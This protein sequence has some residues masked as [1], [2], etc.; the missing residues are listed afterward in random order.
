MKCP[1]CDTINPDDSKFCKECAAPLTKVKGVSFTVTLKA[2]KAGFS[3]GT[4]IAGKYKI[5]EEIGRGGMAVVYKA[6]DTRLKRIVALKFLSAE[7]TQNKEAKQRFIQEAQAAAALDHPNICTVHEVDEADEQT[8]IAMSYI[9]GKSLKDKLRDGPLDVEEAREIAL[10]VAEGLKEAH[11][12]GIVHRDIKPANIM[13]TD[14]SI[15]KIT[16]FGLAKLSG[17]ADL[18]KAS[19]IMGTVAYMSPEQAKGEEV[20]HRSDI[21]SLGAMVYEML[22]GERPFKKDQEH[23]LIYSILSE[24][25]ITI[26]KIRKDIP[27][28]IEVVIEKSL[29]KEASNRYQKI[30][31]LITDLEQSVPLIFPKAEKSIVVLPFEDMSPNKDQEYFSDGLTEEIISD[32]SSIQS[33]RVIS[34]TS[35]MMLKGTKKSM[36]TIGR[37]LDVQYVLEGSVR[38]A[39][40]KLRITAQLIDAS[41]DAHL[42][43]E[44]YNGTLD[45]VFDIQENVSR[46][47]V[48]ALKLKLSADEDKKISE[49]PITDIRA[50]ECYLK[51]LHEAW[52][53]TPEGLEKA[54]Q[55]LRNGLKIIGENVLFYEGLATVNL[56]YVAGGIKL[57]QNLLDEAKAYVRKIFT[58]DPENAGGH[59][60]LG[61]TAYKVGD[62][63]TAL[64]QCKKTYLL[65]PNHTMNLAGLI[66]MYS[67]SGRLSIAT[68]FAKRL[69]EIDPLNPY[70]DSMHGWKLVMEG[71]FE[72]AILAHKRTVEQ[73]PQSIFYRFCYGQS[74]AYNNQVEEACSVFEEIRQSVDINSSFYGI[75]SFYKYSLLGRKKKR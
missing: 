70:G 2:P 27:S 13:L 11:E 71:R 29:E 43:A 14:R 47:I 6:E 56:W 57:E 32:L 65:D 12:K 28:H 61:M 45:D 1:K 41:S 53:F 48:A 51:A 34:R 39:G 69:L 15:A 26:S 58:M 68:Q 72:D 55:Y 44:K 33:L 67:E 54:S 21:W 64:K 3:K 30:Q 36:K 17:G 7:L 49:R 75:V 5:I 16:D 52:T 42:W 31:E 4:V 20:D 19:T 63:K 24:D 40:N 46:S 59:Y 66:I 8:F 25:P 50:Y 73:E 22:S 35:A 62:Y 9:E 10:Q 38:T 60:I 37:E 23:A 74:L 18:T